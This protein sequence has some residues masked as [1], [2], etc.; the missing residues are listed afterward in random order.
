MKINKIKRL[1]TNERNK[2]FRIRDVYMRKI[3]KKKLKDIGSVKKHGRSVS[4]SQKIRIYFLWREPVF[5]P[6]HF[7]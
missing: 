3:E 6:V 4:N 7:N 5:V 1:K 2:L